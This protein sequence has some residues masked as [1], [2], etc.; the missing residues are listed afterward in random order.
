MNT[1]LD[2]GRISAN[3]RF[4]FYI[5]EEL[6]KVKILLSLD[7]QGKFNVD[8]VADIG[9]IYLEAGKNDFAQSYAKQTLHQASQLEQSQAEFLQNNQ[10]IAIAHYVLATIK[11]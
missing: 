1:R 6:N 3:F 10:V 2:P 8:V 7:K 4:Q 5:D 9:W 11:R